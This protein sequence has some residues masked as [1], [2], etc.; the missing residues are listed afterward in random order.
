MGYSQPTEPVSDLRRRAERVLGYT[1]KGVYNTPG[2]IVEDGHLVDVCVRTSL[3]TWD[4]NQLTRLV[5]AAHR[6]LM[7]VELSGDGGPGRIRIRLT[8]RKSFD[9]TDRCIMR[10]HP[11][12]S[13][14]LEMLGEA[15]PVVTAADVVGVSA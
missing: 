13:E 2:K 1:F 6:E 11:S 3:A 9:A 8:R 10:G 14:H 4:F 12:L 7:R 15:L 5:V